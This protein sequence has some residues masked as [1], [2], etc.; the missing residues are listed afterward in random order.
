MNR[1]GVEKVLA[2][3]Q[4]LGKIP[5]PRRSGRKNYIF[6]CPFHSKGQKQATPSFGVQVETG[7]WNCFNPT[8]GRKGPTIQA[9]YS[10]LTGIPEAEASVVFPT[11][12]GATDDLRR[13]LG[14]SPTALK[15]VSMAPFPLVGLISD[16][17]EAVAYMARRKIPDMVW[18]KMGIRYCAAPRMASAYD[19]KTTVGGRRIVFPIHFPDGGIGFMGRSIGKDQMPKWRPI[20]NTDLFFYDPLRLL[21]SNCREVVL[22]EGEFDVAACIREGLPAMGCFGA[23][24]GFERIHLLQQFDK[25]M[26]LFDGD[27]PGYDGVSASFANHGSVLKGK[28]FN[29]P[30]P[31]GYDPAKLPVGFGSAVRAKLT[32][33]ISFAD[34]LKGKLH[35]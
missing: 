12:L 16:H 35:V 24:L 18:N 1:T 3:L 17:A 30:T 27:G 11:D 9:L 7:E 29:F 21:G 2:E 34:T 13:R 10:A 20:E 22:V 5:A 26:L 33:K 32:E 4:K 25:I 15:P 6:D 31:D 8:C 14:A 19:A 28:L 23:R